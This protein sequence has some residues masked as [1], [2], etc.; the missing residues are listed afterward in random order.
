[1]IPAGVA[2]PRAPEPLHADATS[3]LLAFEPDDAGQRTLRDEYLAHLAAHPDACSRAGPPGHLTA[4]CLI[5][6][7]SASRTLL[8]LHRK[9]GFWVQCGGHLEAGDPS[10]AAGALRE[11]RE[12]TGVAALTL[13]RRTPVDLDRHALSAAFGRCR[14]HWDVGFLAVL[15]PEGV[16]GI[17]VVSAESDDVAW[18]PVDDLPPGT[19]ADLPRRLARARRALLA[20]GG[21]GVHRTRLTG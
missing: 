7:P 6:D 5:L 16:D 8:T 2:A 18:W 10:V 20:D 12:E 1:V 21:A 3:A 17:P 14:V 15:D 4:S 19:V 11:G 9:G 13:W